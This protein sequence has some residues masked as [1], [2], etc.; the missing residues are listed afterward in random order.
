MKYLVDTQYFKNASSGLPRP[1]FFYAGNEGAIETF[2][3]N[4][5]FMTTT[6][7]KEYGALVVFGE[8]R[9]F[10]SSFPFA[11]T[12]AFKEGNNSYLTVENTMMDY[13]EL[14]KFIKT[15]YGAEDKAVI[16]F[17]GSYG[18]MLAAWLRM[19]FPHVF[20]GALA[21]SAPL[22]YF[23]NATTAQE[24]AFSM[25]A[26]ADFNTTEVGKACADGIKKGLVLLNTTDSK[27]YDSINKN[28]LPC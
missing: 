5:G 17:G 19:K 28:F 4:S 20:Q 26:T 10:G 8:H 3:A 24:D 18:G 14:I 6:L 12:E 25:I 23:Q 27:S 22:V 1:I 16:T 7:A 15:K 9:Y 13:V 2:Y 11:K 21:A